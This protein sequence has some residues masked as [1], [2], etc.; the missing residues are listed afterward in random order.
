M[1]V[2]DKLIFDRLKTSVQTA[3]SGINKIQGELSS[4]KKVERPSDDPVVYAKATLVDAQKSVNT[5]LNRNLASIKTLGGMYESTFNN[6]N[7]LLT[8]AKQLALQY[9]DDTISPADRKTGA[10][11]VENIIEQLVTLGNTK[12]SNTYIFGG[13]RANQAP[14]DLN[15]DYSVNY[16]VP[17]GGRQPIDAYV[18][19][20]ELG[21]TGF[22]GQELFYDQS[23][24]LYEDPAN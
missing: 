21:T 17:L 16:K 7:D 11:A 1:R 18:D 4:G 23:K 6:V 5:Q 15:P 19:Q 13:T 9:S 3:M 12:L 20:A 22:S 24:V 10:Q 14:Y 8:Q 2:T